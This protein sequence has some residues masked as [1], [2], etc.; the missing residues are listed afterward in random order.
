M[1]LAYL[2]DLQLS[3]IFLTLSCSR[4]S[5]GTQVILSWVS[6]RKTFGSFSLFDPVRIGSHGMGEISLQRQ[7]GLSQP[8]NPDF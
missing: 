4:S 7:R 8:G 6:E 5:G 3:I 2:K 1:D